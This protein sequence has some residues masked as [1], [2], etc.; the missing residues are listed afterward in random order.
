[1]QIIELTP[2]CTLALCIILWPV[3][4][5]AISIL[6]LLIKDKHLSN[7]SFIFKT[8]S[9]EAGGEIYNRFFKIRK[10]KKFL[11]DGA[12]VLKS[13]YKKKHL[14]N[15]SIENLEKFVIES[16]RAELQHWLSILPF[17]I[18]G[19]FAPTYILKY[20][21]IYALIVNLP[22]AIAQRYNRPRVV[23]LLKKMKSRTEILS[24][25]QTE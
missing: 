14:N 6:C 16:C 9:W 12:A 7:S 20:M 21:L 1:M 11:P 19:L 15:S 17:W 23:N 25:E 24:R 13:G 8:H 10:W 4:Q 3:I 5:A 2:I 18:F 22:C